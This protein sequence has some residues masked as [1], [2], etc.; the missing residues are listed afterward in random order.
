M[1][2]F[3]PMFTV[4]QMLELGVF[5]GG[6]FDDGTHA[7]YTSTRNL[8]APNVSLDK[9]KW[10][11][12]GW[13]TPEDPLGWVQWYYRYSQGRRIESLD[14]WQISRWR[15]FI[16]RHGAQVK[17]N[18]NGDLSKRIRQRQCLLHWAADPIPDID[19]K[20]KFEYLM[21]MKGTNRGH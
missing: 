19:M 10:I 15:S 20:N 18:G 13:I 11:D 6:Y 9:Q 1:A 17:K 3:T 16:A 2:D 4:K 5:D 21:K 12:N 7:E 14:K 8:F